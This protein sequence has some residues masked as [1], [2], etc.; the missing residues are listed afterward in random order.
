MLNLSRLKVRAKLALLMGLSTLAVVVT[1]IASAS[2]LHQ[3]MY[4]DRVDKLRA[5]V[6]SARSYA[7]GLEARVVAGKLTHDQA[8]EVLREYIRSWEAHDL[9]ALVRLLRDDVTLAMPPH[10]TWFHGATVGAFFGSQRFAGF[11][12]RGTRLV[13]THANDQLALAFYAGSPAGFVPHSIQLVRFEADRVAE[14][15]QF[16]GADYF[17]GFAL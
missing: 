17:R 4:D 5:V 7:E 2:A 6:Q 10:A 14:I 1:V 8:Y 16:I 13:P 9:E 11:W 12:D 15:A 3:R